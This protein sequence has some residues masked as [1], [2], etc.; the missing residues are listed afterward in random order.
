METMKG[1]NRIGSSA[2]RVGRALARLAS[3]AVLAAGLMIAP[4]AAKAASGSIELMAGHEASILDT[5]LS[6]PVA[7]RASLFFRN[8]S[9]VNYSSRVS[10]FTLLDVSYNVKGGLNLVYETQF[11]VQ[12]K[13]SYLACLRYFRKDGDFSLFVG[14]G[15]T[16]TEETALTTQLV[17][18]YAP[19]INATTRL[20]A[21]LEM[22]S[23]GDKVGHLG[24]IGR[25]RLGVERSGFNAGLALDANRFRGT[26]KTDRNLG[27]F[28]QKDF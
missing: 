26:G 11:T 9:A 13:T 12:N 7:G 6:V 1:G 14:P 25:A 20:L 22:F 24:T 19:P 10:P 16:L 2:D 5:K 23:T 8:R 27:I 28:L 3:A 17:L 4:S 18:R 21:R 15:V